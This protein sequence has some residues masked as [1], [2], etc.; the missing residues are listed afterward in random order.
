[1]HTEC[2]PEQYEFSAIERR[3]VVAGF[4]GGQVTSDGGALLLKQVDEPLGVASAGGFHGVSKD[5]VERGCVAK[6]V[7]GVVFCFELSGAHRDHV[8]FGRDRCAVTWRAGESVLPRL[9]RP[10][11]LPAAVYFLRSAIAVREVAAREHR[12]L[13]GYGGGAGTHCRAD[14]G[15]LAAGSDHPASGLGL[16]PRGVDGLVR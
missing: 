5:P 9:L 2:N 4:D 11:L 1:M 10:V 6:A 14:Q 8:G 12:W 7:R 15:T 13:S 3:R 16:L